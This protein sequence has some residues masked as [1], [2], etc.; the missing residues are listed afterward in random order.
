MQSN[1]PIAICLW[2]KIVI[3]FAVKKWKHYFLDQCVV[4]KTLKHLLEQPP[5]AM[6]QNWGLEKLIGLDFKTKYK[7]DNESVPTYVFSRT[8]PHGTLVS[9]CVLTS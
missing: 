6:L 4:I 5:T 3:L 7:K 1:H 8:P 2:K 9:L